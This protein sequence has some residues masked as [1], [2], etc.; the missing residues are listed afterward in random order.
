MIR[1][2][3]NFFT[4]IMQRWLPD[5]FIFAIILTFIVFIAGMLGE[6]KSPSQMAN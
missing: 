3:S 4:N 2:L 1:T 6:S 5:A